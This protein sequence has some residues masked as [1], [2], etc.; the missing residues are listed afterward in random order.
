MAIKLTFHSLQM[1]IAVQSCEFGDGTAATQPFMEQHFS[2]FP[3]ISYQTQKTN[4]PFMFLPKRR[5]YVNLCKI[6][7]LELLKKDLYFTKN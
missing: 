3:F 4:L 2:L 1:K 6:F 7:T 5:V